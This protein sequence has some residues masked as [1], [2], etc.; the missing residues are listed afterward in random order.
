MLETHGA[1]AEEED[2]REVLLK[3]A[4]VCE[5]DPYWIA[6]AYG[7]ESKNIYQEVTEDTLSEEPVPKKPMYFYQK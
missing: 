6:P 5:K 3:Y 7:P 2:P 4:E 1:P